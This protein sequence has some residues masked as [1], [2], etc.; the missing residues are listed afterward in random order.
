MRNLLIGIGLIGAM[1]LFIYLTAGLGNQSAR[2][3]YRAA[4]SNPYLEQI[5]SQ[6]RQRLL[7]GVPR[8][9]P[10]EQGSNGNRFDPGPSS[11]AADESA[12]MQQAFNALDRAIQVMQISGLK[13]GDTV[14]GRIAAAFNITE[15][16][17]Y[18][19]YTSAAR[20]KDFDEFNAVYAGNPQALAIYSRRQAISDLIAQN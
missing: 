10:K 9:A 1:G 12:L 16:M 14:L 13:E 11:G 17:V 15:R 2:G 18:N 7:Y 4:G 3:L 5:S 6:F 20:A 8:A 19:Y